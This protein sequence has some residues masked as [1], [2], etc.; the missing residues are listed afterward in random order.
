[1]SENR[2]WVTL[3]TRP[4][5]LAG[6]V[7]LA[8]T[9]KKHRSRYP[10]I[11]LVTDTLPQGCIDVLQSEDQGS[12]HIIIKKV[13]PLVPQQ[14]VNVVAQ[15]FEDTWTKLRVFSLLEYDKIIFL[16]ADILIMGEMDP[17]FEIT[18]TGK[19]WLGANQ[20]CVCNID[21]DAW[22]PP[23][24]S[25]E[26]CAWSS[27]EHPAALAQGPLI[28]PESPPTYHLMNSGV[29]IFHPSASMW[30]RIQTFLNTTPLL[31]TFT[32]PDQHFLDEFFRNKWVS[33][34]WQWNA[35]KTRRYWHENIWRD[36]E[37]RAL[38]YIVDKPWENRI[39]RDG[40]AGYK[41]RDGVTHKWWW[42]AFDE[43]EAEKENNG[44]DTSLKLV[45]E[46]VAKPIGPMGP[47]MSPNSVLEKGHEA[48][49]NPL[50][51]LA[52]KKPAKKPA[53]V[54]GQ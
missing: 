18:L 48:V 24:W 36:E 30:E 44:E 26:N 39:G 41:G 28:T 6:A 20:A 8:H 35:T 7:L 21:R 43:W 47:A 9:L 50:T 33:I 46:H 15:R 12:G 42:N 54:T 22:A 40:V 29:F 23:E 5:Y 14:K 25:K 10:L 49:V 34:P 16:D 53:K 1:M 52:A 11:V 37:V 3:L 27:Q 31:S 51:E 13:D 2:A 17:M 4:S 45:R 32:F 19:D 38:H